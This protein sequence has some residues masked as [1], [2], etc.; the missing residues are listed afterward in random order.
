MSVTQVERSFIADK[1]KLLHE[2]W[3][4]TS[5]LTTSNGN[6]FLTANLERADD[7]FTGHLGAA[8][9]ESSGVFTFP[10]TGVFKISFWP[11]WYSNSQGHSSYVGAPIYVTENNSDYYAL[12]EQYDSIEANGDHAGV[13]TSF[14]FDV[15]NVTTH[16]L[17]LNC[18]SEGAMTVGSSST[19]NKT[20]A[21]FEFLG[22]T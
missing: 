14:V 4:L 9:A 18:Y 17:K 2:T 7:D 1:E 15:T 3:R 8:M 13:S 16:K 19:T 10:Y 22:D 12:C 6:N 5:D 21:I 11:Y 20:Y